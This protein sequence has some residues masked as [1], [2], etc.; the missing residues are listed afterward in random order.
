MGR[1]TQLHRTRTVTGSQPTRH[2][3]NTVHGDILG[4]VWQL[5]GPRRVD[6]GFLPA[7]TQGQHTLIELCFMRTR[8]A[9]ETTIADVDGAEL[10]DAGHMKGGRNT[11]H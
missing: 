1:D 3:R 4:P 9:G 6:K 2:I 7:V 8:N 5:G 11:V 10:V